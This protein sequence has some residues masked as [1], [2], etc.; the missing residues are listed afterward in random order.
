MANNEEIDF[1]KIYGNLDKR[2]EVVLGTPEKFKKNLEKAKEDAEK[3]REDAKDLYEQAL[4]EASELGEDGDGEVKKIKQEIHELYADHLKEINAIAKSFEESEKEKETDKKE[5]EGAEAEKKEKRESAGKWEEVLKNVDRSLEILEGMPE[6]QKTPRLKWLVESVKSAKSK[7]GEDGKMEVEFKGRTQR[8]GIP[9]DDLIEELENIAS[10]IKKGS[11]ITPER[12]GDIE[13]EI[14]KLKKE[15]DEINKQVQEGYK[16]ENRTVI[17]RKGHEEGEEVRTPDRE[18]EVLDREKRIH[19]LE[20]ELLGEKNLDPEK[21]KQIAE[22]EGIVKLLEENSKGYFEV[23]PEMKDGNLQHERTELE[24]KL[25]SLDYR[26]TGSM[27]GDYKLAMDAIGKRRELVKPEEETEPVTPEPTPQPMPEPM[28]EPI[29]EPVP[30][31]TPEPVPSIP[32]KEKKGYIIDISEIVKAYAWR[33]A[34]GKMRDLLDNSGFFK[35][36]F[37]RLGEK[38]YLMKFYKESLDAIQSNKNLMAEIETRVLQRSTAKS[39]GKDRSYD[40]LDSLIDE[41]VQEIEDADERG[42]LVRDPEL[43]KEISLL[44]SE[45]ALNSMTREEF[46][47]AVQERIMPHLEGRKFT[48]DESREGD[49]EGLMYAN[50]LFSLAENFKKELDEKTKEYGP[51]QREN[52]LKEMQAE[53]ALDIQLGLKQKD[54][55]ETKPKP[56]L[57]WYEKFVDATQNIPVLNKIMGNPVAYGVLGGIAGSFIGKGAARAAAGA[58]LVAIAGLSPWMIPLVLGAAFGGTYAGMRRSRDLQYD[59]GMDLRRATLGAESGGKRTDQIREFHYDQKRAED[60]I[61]SLRTIAEKQEATED[62]RRIVAEIIAR[63][64]VEKEKEV[65]LIGA[66]EEEGNEYKTKAIVMKDLKVSLKEVREKFNLTDE[67]LQQLVEEQEKN[68]TSH[69]EENDANFNRFKRNEALKAGIMG[70]AI[71]LGAGAAGQWATYE[72]MG[73]AGHAPKGESALEHLYHYMQGDSQFENVGLVSQAV[74]L[75]GGIKPNIRIP[76]GYRLMQNGDHFNLMN[77]EGRAVAENIQFE[78]DGS[79]TDASKEIIKQSGLSSQERVGE[80]MQKVGALEYLKDRLGIHKRV[81]WHDEAGEKFSSFFNRAIEFEGKQQMLQFS[82]SPDG[83]V[84]VDAS[85]IIG[86]LSKNIEGAFNEFGTNPDGSV[87]T[88]LSGLKEQLMTWQKEG[89]LAKHLQIAI[90]PTEEA[91][92]K[93]LSV[94]VE[95]AGPDG[96]IKFP[97]DLSKLFTPQNGNPFKYVELRIDGHVIATAT[98]ENM[99]DMEVGSVGTDIMAPK[100]WDVPPVLP[101]NSRKE[102]EGKGKRKKE[103]KRNEDNKPVERQDVN[104]AREKVSDNEIAEEPEKQTP[105]EGEKINVTVENGQKNDNKSGDVAVAETVEKAKEVEAEKNEAKEVSAENGA[106]IGKLS[107]NE[108]AEDFGEGELSIEKKNKLKEWLKKGDIYEIIRVLNTEDQAKKL[109]GF[110]KKTFQRKNSAEMGKLLSRFGEDRR[111]SLMGFWEEENQFKTPAKESRNI[112]V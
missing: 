44:F 56:V 79:L 14:S 36:S 55:Y 102:L 37:V 18:K 96:K 74:E 42:E 99:S 68:F 8:E 13:S 7:I 47:K 111:I 95:G 109:A 23:H 64:N 5:E 48:M 73:L 105:D 98:G 28:P 17:E 60:L 2:N 112:S 80:G 78:K 75:P 25:I 32:K 63:I 69:I 66:S 59:R 6:E 83:S 49:A 91:S 11:E 110:L 50:N 89:T 61:Q 90:I 22:I 84:S 19:E 38:G 58:G 77:G 40:V 33:E 1:E 88:K 26:T 104:I 92:Q 87:D 65:D 106:E 45:Y 93:G 108:L 4:K 76:E 94:L 72:A 103:D 3:A 30:E 71:G 52:V 67:Q 16:M 21:E 34:E 12:K 27:E 43:N 86:N 97:E 54:L 70:A 85:R 9:V 46:D 39:E 31:P 24:A 41:Y 101:F 107:F 53:F 29:P 10:G 51:D 15:I 62:D 35:K 82:K 57:A 100:K 81:N 20:K